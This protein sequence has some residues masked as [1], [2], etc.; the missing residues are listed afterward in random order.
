MPSTPI[1][2]LSSLHQERYP[3]PLPA[4]P[5]SFFLF[6]QSSLQLYQPTNLQSQF[7]LSIRFSTFKNSGVRKIHP[8]EG[9][10]LRKVQGGRTIQAVTSPHLTGIALTDIRSCNPQQFD[11]I[12]RVQRKF[13]DQLSLSFHR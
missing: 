12:H 6:F 2:A 4:T 13:I 7:F 1:H 10:Q 11:K 8:D 3:L 5:V 9:R